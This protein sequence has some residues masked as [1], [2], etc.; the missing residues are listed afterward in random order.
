MGRTPS[1]LSY[2]VGDQVRVLA[3]V[4]LLLSLPPVLVVIRF[5]R[6][7]R[8]LLRASDVAAVA[9]PGDPTPA[10]IVS[11]TEAADRQLPGSRTCLVRSLT[12]ETL[13]RLYAFTPDHRIGVTKGSDGA[14][15]AHSWLEFDGEILIGDLE[16]LSQ[17][18]PLPP[19]NRGTNS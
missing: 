7:R 3:A 18:E 14:V 13:L 2:S 9:I 6:V 4:A 17:Y 10:R 11:A 5:E 19:L 12:T 15:K 8:F 16:D 1:F